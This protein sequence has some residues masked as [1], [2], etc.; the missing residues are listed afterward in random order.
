[1]AAQASPQDGPQEPEPSAG[2]A[3]S[4]NLSDL[5]TPAVF[6]APS[7]AAPPGN[8]AAMPA[9]TAREAPAASA[10]PAL[11]PNAALAPSPSAA[12][13]PTSDAALPPA[14]AAAP[15]LTLSAALAPPPD[16]APALTPDAALASAAD[17]ALAPPP[18]AAV[19]QAGTPGISRTSPGPRSAFPAL[20][21]VVALLPTLSGPAPTET[22]ATSHSSTRGLRSLAHAVRAETRRADRDRRRAEALYPA[23]LAMEPARRLDRIARG[24]RFASPALARR[25]LAEAR[26]TARNRPALARE[27]A[28]L[29]LAVVARLHA[30]RPGTVTVVALRAAAYARCA[31]ALWSAGQSGAAATALAA[32]QADLDATPLGEPEHALYCRIAAQVQAG[33]GRMDDALALLG[34]AAQLYRDQED[35]EALALCRIEH[36]WLLVHEDPQAA[37]PPLRNALHLLG[38]D[39]DPW[40]SVRVRQGLALALAELGRPLEAAPMQR[41]A[42]DLAPGLAEEPDQ[43][44]AAWNDAQIDARIGRPREAMA[45]LPSLVERWLARGE[46]FP[47]ALAALDLAE[48]Y[49]ETDRWLALVDLER[50]EPR[51][52]AAGLPSEAA[53]AYRAV[54]GLAHRE[55]PSATYP[56]VHLRA[57]LGR[58][59]HRPDL[60]YVPCR[61]AARALPWDDLPLKSR[62]EICRLAGVEPH[63]ATLPAAAVGPDLRKLLAWTHLESTGD[64]I[65]WDGLDE[66]RAGLRRVVG[67]LRAAEAELRRLAALLPVPSDAG[68]EAPA[69]RRSPFRPSLPPPPS[70]P[71][72]PPLPLPPLWPHPSDD[73]VHLS[74]AIDHTLAA[75]LA[76]A[77]ADLTDAAAGATA[78]SGQEVGR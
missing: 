29:A 25:L 58:A 74:G 7:A 22:P 63:T 4:P 24:R 23:L 40:A 46:A 12:L 8:A 39:A 68:C 41:E 13:P 50:L 42:R 69:P 70:L 77:L 55:P 62:R 54:V 45:A 14:A 17:T 15:A 66:V 28:G 30:E 60:A 32:A 9:A 49:V 48:L 51:L 6:P 36:G 21:N 35:A 2:A 34:R 53:L 33:E 72:H 11:A 75:H 76:P 56:L 61:T 67:Q 1:M 38:P 26:A 52:R 16:A 43:L 57:W 19:P 44:H 27:L 5:P 37:L 20:T 78:G 10:A 73:A 59:R 64:H 65:E 47:A 18:N 31:E 71:A 3:G